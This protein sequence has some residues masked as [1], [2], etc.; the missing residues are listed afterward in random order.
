[1]IS[2]IHLLLIKLISKMPLGMVR[3]IGR[4]LGQIYYLIPTKLRHN[5]Q[6]NIG[7]CFPEL[8]EHEQEKLLHDSLIETFQTMME[9]PAIWLGSPTTWVDMTE[10]GENI[11][12]LRQA[13]EEGKGVIMAGPHQ[14]NWE[15]G[16]H[17]LSSRF[18]VTAIYRPPRKEYLNDLIEE[19]RR[20]GGGDLAPATVQGVKKLI[21]ALKKG[22]MLLLLTD[23]VPKAAGKQGNVFAPFFGRQAQTM[24]LVNSLVR[25]TGAQ[26]FF[27]YF[28]R[29]AS[30][31]Y[32]LNCFKA[33]EGIDD[34]NVEEAAAA[35]NLGLEECIRHRPEQYLW[36]YK[37]FEKSPDGG[38]SP[39]SRP[40]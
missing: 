13:M 32:R 26:V 24:V 23:Q 12:E 33:P 3:G 4:L 39:Y 30:G 36:G 40:K 25:K 20:R 6:V 22:E 2:K 37:K 31:K 7:I 38:R 21:T 29:L 17:Y 14:G 8:S 5:H 28:E 11:S 15:L 34:P 16:F 27:F 9:L 10:E 35:I 18:P 1:M 19:G